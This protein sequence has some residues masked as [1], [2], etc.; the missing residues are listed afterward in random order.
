M[1][2]YEQMEAFMTWWIPQRGCVFVNG[3]SSLSA[4]SN[5][6]LLGRSEFGNGDGEPIYPER[7]PHLC[8]RHLGPDQQ[9]KG[10]LRLFSTAS[11][12]FFENSTTMITYQYYLPTSE[13][14]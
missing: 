11:Q 12:R 10:P 1:L 9:Q 6:L 2:A 4:D 14:C 3:P 13:S 7:L 8:I 5:P